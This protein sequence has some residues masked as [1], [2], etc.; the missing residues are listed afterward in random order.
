VTYH[1][2]VRKVRKTHG[3]AVVAIGMSLFQSVLFVAAFYLMF[4]IIGARTMAIRGD[5][6][7]YLCPGSSCIS[8]ISRRLAPS[9]RPRTRP[10]R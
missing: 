4:T 9:W 8:F 2:S 1:A 5:F 10:L 7:L 3:N 6:M